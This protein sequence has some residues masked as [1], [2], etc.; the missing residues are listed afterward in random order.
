MGFS[1]SFS[2]QNQPIHSVFTPP[3]WANYSNFRF[4][5]HF[6][7]QKLMFNGKKRL[8]IFR[9]VRSP[10]VRRGPEDQIPTF[11]VGILITLHILCIASGCIH[12]CSEIST[13]I[14]TVNVC[15]SILVSN[16]QYLISSLLFSP[17]WSLFSSFLSSYLILMTEGFPISISIRCSLMSTPE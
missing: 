9:S 2:Q 17:H 16:L 5:D 13:S 3:S 10:G 7:C 15:Q 8:A 4:Q 14:L 11:G 6:L 1:C 12:H